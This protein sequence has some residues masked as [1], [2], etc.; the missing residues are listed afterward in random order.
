VDPTLETL[1]ARPVLGLRCRLRVDEIAARLEELIPRVYEL[2]G[3]LA[4]GP[5]LTRWHEW[6]PEGG[7]MEVALPVRPG[8]A[9]PRG[10]EDSTLPGGP[11]LV[12]VHV[13]PY[14]GLPAA[15]RAALAWRDAH[16]HAGRDDPWEEYV[17]DC[18]K[19]PPERLRTKL[20]LPVDRA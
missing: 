19:T 6:T 20:V 9:A 8:T 3:P 13:G 17:D 18:D 1:A 7:V 2:A 4:V 12:F 11:A 5:M 16:G 14:A 15:W 10:L